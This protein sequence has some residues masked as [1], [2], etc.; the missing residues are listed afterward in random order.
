[1]IT[2][3]QFHAIHDLSENQGLDSAQ[4]GREL[5]LS[6]K[7]V[8]RWLERDR[9]EPRR[10]PRRTSI[11]DPFKSEINAMLA[12]CDYSAVQIFQ[13]LR[14]RGYRG[15][16]SLVRDH[17]RRLRPPEREAFLTLR[18][19][20][21]DRAQVD[22]G[23]CGKIRIGNTVRKFF[24]FVMTLC[25]SRLMYVEITMGQA[26]E[27]FLQGHRNAFQYFNAVPRRMM[28]DN[29]KT[30]I[31]EHPPVGT[32][33]PN[34]RYADLGKHYGFEIKACRPRRGNEKG[35]V[36]NGVKYFKNNFL[37]GYEPISLASLEADAREWLEN[38][39]NV[40]VHATTRRRPVDM[41]EEERKLL[42][43]PPPT[44]YDCSTPKTVNSDNKFRVSYDGNRYS[45]PFKHASARDL[46][47]RA[48]PDR[49]TIWRKTE[50]LAEHRRSYERG[51]DIEKP[52]HAAGLLDRKRAASKSRAMSSFLAISPAAEAFHQGLLEKRRPVWRNVRNV[53]EL[54]SLH[55]RNRVVAAL[56]EANHFRAFSS[57]FI[58][59]HLQTRWN[60]AETAAETHLT[61]KT[62]LLKIEVE[63][64][65]FDHFDDIVQ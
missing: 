27:H 46:L 42:L 19:D 65:E 15:G 28:V 1:M 21:G 58:A 9:Y 14:R 5:G 39:A 23:E 48:L 37:R 59:N 61:R 41:F 22:F 64:P 57:D 16:Y 8:K 20:P 25:W 56:E 29:C 43:P 51:L 3:H 6:R 30:A 24:V 55:G 2:Y 38:T 32:P 11:L 53:L 45:V 50:L 17:V 35:R 44:P 10:S 49:L 31:L 47:L 33:V 13:E 54:M 7:T 62:D 40:R 63:Q 60:P 34:P 26:A 52:E 12:R 18:F 4:I 36:E